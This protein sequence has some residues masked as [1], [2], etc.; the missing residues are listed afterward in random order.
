MTVGVWVGVG[1]QTEEQVSFQVLQPLPQ[2]FVPVPQV[3]TEH[4]PQLVT[5][6]TQVDGGG[7][8]LCL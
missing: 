8:S 3:V 4:T 7:S 5:P 1:V 2:V 6:A